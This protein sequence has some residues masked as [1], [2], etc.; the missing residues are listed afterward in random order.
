MTVLNG[1]LQ[2][3]EVVDQVQHQPDD[4]EHHEQRYE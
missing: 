3:H 2:R 1:R 4:D